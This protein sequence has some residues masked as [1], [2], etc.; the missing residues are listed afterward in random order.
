MNKKK[1]GT[2]LYVSSGTFLCGR[3]K[4]YKNKFSFI[5]SQDVIEDKETGNH[6]RRIGSLKGKA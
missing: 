5:N 6:G 1:Q 4:V 3:T 2:E